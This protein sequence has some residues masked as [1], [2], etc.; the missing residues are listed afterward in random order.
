MTQTPFVHK[1]HE[2][3]ISGDKHGTKLILPQI[4]KL[5]NTETQT[6]GFK[7]APQKQVSRKVRKHV[8]GGP[9]KH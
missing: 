3:L 6:Q 9:I 4:Q 1:G 5:S 8:E 2:A 7:R